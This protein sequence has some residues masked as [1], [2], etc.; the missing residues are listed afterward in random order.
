MRCASAVLVGVA[1]TLAAVPAGAVVPRPVEFPPP[2]LAIVVSPV[3][4]GLERPRLV[5]PPAP[6]VAAPSLELGRAPAP[7]F[8]SGVSKPL[9]AATDPGGFACA[10]V[11]FRRAAALAECGVSRVLSGDYRA[12]RESFEESLAVDPRGAQAASAHV[13][14]GELALLEATSPTSPAAGRAERHYRTALPLGPPPP[15]NIHAELGLGLL[16]LRRGDAAEAE[17]ALDR[18]LRAVPAQPLALVARYLLGVTRLL[19]DRPA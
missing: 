2:S 14:L 1:L 9:P 3:P 13:W 15:L 19:L 10:F 17:A 18:A 12:A 11:A 7:R 16:M 6:P 5:P 8:I 4:I